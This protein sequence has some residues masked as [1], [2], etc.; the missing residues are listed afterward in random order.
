L[1]NRNQQIEEIYELITEL[2]VGNLTKRGNLYENDEELDTITLGVN[3]LAEEL[4]SST[5][6]RDYL[7]KIY[8]SIP[9]LVFELDSNFII[10]K[11]NE[12]GILKLHKKEKDI[13]G[14]RIVN[15]IDL[16]KSQKKKFKEDPLKFLELRQ[17]EMKV[18]GN[19]PINV[20]INHTELEDEQR[21]QNGYFWIARDV[22]EIVEQG[23]VIAELNQELNMFIYRSSHDLKGPLSS[24]KGLLNI[25][26][27]DF[28]DPEIFNSTMNYLKDSIDKLD[29]IVFDFINLGNITQNES[30]KEKINFEEVLHNIHLRLSQTQG[31]H[32]VNFTQLIKVDKEFVCNSL[33]LKTI[34]ENLLSNGVVFRDTN[35]ELNKVFLQISCT[36][37]RLEIVVEDNG[38]GM[39]QRSQSRMFE[40]F[41]KGLNI[42]KGSGMGLYLVKSCVSA[43]QGKIQVKTTLGEGTKITIYLPNNNQVK[44]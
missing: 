3:M 17:A 1:V 34:I 32:E 33:M 26:H 10:Q 21:N 30:R 12:V 29:R 15:F 23:K 40:M 39:N 25:P 14:K 16:T 28:L 4:Q 44:T 27:E 35:K 43:M 8:K 37:K 7:D 36:G 42:S 20:L 5:I 9:E 11:V 18:Y 38:L 41:F 2:A 31:Y 19:E 13:I 6:S 22:T 24:M